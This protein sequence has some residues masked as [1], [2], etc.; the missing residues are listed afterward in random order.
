MST[1]VHARVFERAGRF[2]FEITGPDGRPVVLHSLGQVAVAVA[3]GLAGARAPRDLT[4]L[5]VAEL[6]LR[7][8]TRHGI[9][10]VRELT[11]QDREI[12]GRMLAGRPDPGDEAQRLAIWSGG[13]AR[14][15]ACTDAAHGL[16][17]AVQ[18]ARLAVPAPRQAPALAGA[19]R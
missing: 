4:P 10:H 13:Y 17:W 6:V 19:A 18:R 14:S 5:A 8:I 3:L 9:T 1:Q 7:G 12:N 15:Q 16:I 2:R 11:L